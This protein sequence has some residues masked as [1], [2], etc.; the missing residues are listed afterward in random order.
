MITQMM[1]SGKAI[2]KKYSN[3]TI[4]STEMEEGGVDN[5]ITNLNNREGCCMV[6]YTI[7]GVL[8]S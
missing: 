6:I 8:N 7:G 1:A 2:V 3:Q 5:Y 4:A